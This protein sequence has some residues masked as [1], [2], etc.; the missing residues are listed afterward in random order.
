MTCV[1][2]RLKA[3]DA[4]MIKPQAEARRGV[5]GVFS[6]TC[7][8]VDESS[9]ACES[10]VSLTDTRRRGGYI[11]FHSVRVVCQSSSASAHLYF[12]ASEQ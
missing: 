5:P 2:G 3:K 8:Q 7:C 11:L 6:L 10:Y 1:L 9:A 4:T 12:L